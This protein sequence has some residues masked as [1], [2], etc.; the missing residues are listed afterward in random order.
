MAYETH[1]TMA[2]NCITTS[3]YIYAVIELVKVCLGMITIAA[4]HIPPTDCL[5][6]VFNLWFGIMTFSVVMAVRPILS[7]LFSRVETQKTPEPICSFTVAKTRTASSSPCTR[8]ATKPL[9][10]MR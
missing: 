6:M 9:P 4:K 5:S 2:I 1:V 8:R 10:K 3:L 7:S